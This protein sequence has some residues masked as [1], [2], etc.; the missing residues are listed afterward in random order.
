MAFKA[1]PIV[2]DN[3]LIL[4]GC[5]S[6]TPNEDVIV[7]AVLL[8]LEPCADCVNLAVRPSFNNAT[9][10]PFVVCVND[11]DSVAAPSCVCANVILPSKYPSSK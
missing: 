11:A 5:A 4:V 7:I 3:C 8:V 9:L 2:A 6:L 1:E 10:V